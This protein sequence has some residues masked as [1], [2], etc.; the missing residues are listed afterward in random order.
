MNLSKSKD[1][2]LSIGSLK[3]SNTVDELTDAVMSRYCD[4]LT[5]FVEDF[6][7]FEA[8]LK[9][10]AF[11]GDG[12]TLS[13]V[14]SQLSETLANLHAEGLVRECEQL[15]E[16]IL[17]ASA[18]KFEADLAAF[19]A[20]AATLSVDIQM[21]QHKAEE[22]LKPRVRKYPVVYADGRQ[23]S[24]LA[25]DD[26]PVT[27]NMLK[28][29]LVEAGYKVN[30]V[31]SGAA[32]LDFVGKFT[33]DLFILDIEMPKMNGFELAERLKDVG[34]LAPIVF[35]TGNTTRDYLMKAVKIGAVDFIV[36]PV[37]SGSIAAKIKKVFGEMG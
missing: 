28:T 34:Q 14:L 16:G 36:K 23:R 33:P 18:E 26:I 24:V 1:L 35:L 15:R 7:D 31:T 10:A 32:A 4:L 2:L 9:K 3:L 30:C 20:A 11:I 17:V 6:P 25:V 27:L 21:A 22:A 13:R 19:L 29:T 5:D 37:N 8:A 12:D